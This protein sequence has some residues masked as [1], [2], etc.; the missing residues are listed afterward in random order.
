LVASVKQYPELAAR[1]RPD[2]KIIDVLYCDAAIASATDVL[3]LKGFVIVNGVPQGNGTD[4]IN[5]L[6]TLC[7]DNMAEIKEFAQAAFCKNPDYYN[8]NFTSKY[9]T[10]SSNDDSDDLIDESDN[11]VVNDNTRADDKKAPTTAK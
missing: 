10:S 1:I 11:N 6:I 9:R 7:M 2:G 5:Q 3:Q 8:A 4:I